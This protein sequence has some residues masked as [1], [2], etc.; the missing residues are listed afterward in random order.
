MPGSRKL[1]TNAGDRT[2]QSS[3]ANAGFGLHW[4]I[5]ETPGAPQDVLIPIFVKEEKN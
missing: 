2:Q 5:A 3:A 1:P 4:Q